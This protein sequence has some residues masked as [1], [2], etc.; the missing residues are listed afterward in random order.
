[1]HIRFTLGYIVSNFLIASAFKGSKYRKSIVDF[2]V[3]V[4]VKLIVK[5]KR[6]K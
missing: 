1:M 6:N 2:Y 4:Q 3:I 5:I